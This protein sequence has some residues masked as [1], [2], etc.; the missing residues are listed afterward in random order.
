MRRMVECARPLFEKIDGGGCRDAIGAG[1]RPIVS[2]LHR[3]LGPAPRYKL[4]RRLFF[5][6]SSTEVGPHRKS[7]ARPCA[8]ARVARHAVFR[9]SRRVPSRRV[10][11]APAGSSSSTS[12]ADSP[13]RPTSIGSATTS[14]RRTSG[15]R[16]CSSRPRIAGCWPMGRSRRSPAPPCASSRAPTC[17]SRSR[18][19]RCAT[20]SGRRP[21]H[22]SS[23][24]DCTNS[25]GA[26]AA[27]RRASSAGA[28]R[29]RACRAGRRACSPGRS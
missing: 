8:R 29:S 23:P 3:R 9:S 17:C 2:P 18:R 6:G 19:W 10:P 20:R 14:G 26:V 7:R 24:R 1:S 25:S 28:T 12:P 11:R 4:A 16:S 27:T 13:T 22:A 15:G 21:A 5:S